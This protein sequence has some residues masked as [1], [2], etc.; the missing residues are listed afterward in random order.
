M[1]RIVTP[2]E[3]TSLDQLTIDEG[4]SS[5]NLMEKAGI[6]S[7]KIIRKHI[8]KNDK[9]LVICGTG[10]NGGDGQVI[11]R[12]LKEANY[13][14]SVL[15]TTDQSSLKKKMSPESTRNYELLEDYNIPIFY[16]SSVH[17]CEAIIP[18]YNVIIDCIFGTG[19][20]D[21]PLDDYY[22][23]LIDTINNSKNYV[24]AIDIPSGLNGYNGNYSSAIRAD[25]TIIIQCF[26]TGE[27]LENGPD[28]T[29]KVKIV[30]IGIDTSKKI[31]G[32]EFKYLLNKSEIKFPVKRQNN[33]YKYDY[34]RILILAG[35]K[36]LLGAASLC[37]QSALKTGA[38][39]VT[40]LISEDLYTALVS[41]NPV[42]SLVVPFKI[43]PVLEDINSRKT[44]VLL[45]GPGLGQKY[46]YSSLIGELL[47]E[48]IKI[49]IDADGLKMLKPNIERLKNAKADIIIT[50]HQAEFANLIDV[51]LNVLKADPIKYVTEFAQNN[52]VTVILKSHHT[53]I[54]A[55]NGEIWFNNTGNAG[56]ATPGSGD[57]LAGILSTIFAQLPDSVEAAK[58]AVYYHGLAGDLYVKKY[59]P[60]TLTATDIIDCLK[61][62]L[63]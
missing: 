7:F 45:I 29:G 20:D 23:T 58:A 41:I 5:Q 9:I 50:P 18:E 17:L 53:L 39:L 31:R 55:P 44:D 37:A 2:K 22:K 51:D 26:K 46:N 32:I 27:L 56:M 21:R 30:D 11:A 40:N 12:L 16:A 13:R 19:L 48:E 49:V 14:V 34:G 38:G 15:F 52:N 6:E 59:G 24:I 35:S 54:A 1:K 3:M 60:T 61:H 33:S 42:E 10:N 8:K 36:G 62:I 4:I 28:Q 25:L 47:D 63:A 57:V 43:Q